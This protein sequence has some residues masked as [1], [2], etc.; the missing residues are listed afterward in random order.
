MVWLI[1]ACFAP[2]GA[3][4]QG[5][6]RDDAPDR[7]LWETVSWINSTDDPLCD[8]LKLVLPFALACVRDWISSPASETNSPKRAGKSQTQRKNGIIIP[9]KKLRI[10]ANW[11]CCW[12]LAPRLALATKQAKGTR[13]KA[14]KLRRQ[15]VA[16]KLRMTGPCMPTYNG[17]NF[18]LATKAT[19][20]TSATVHQQRN[21][22]P[23]VE[24]VSPT[25]WLLNGHNTPTGSCGW[26]WWC[27]SRRTLEMG[28][29]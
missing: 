24:T 23:W 7:S 25:L 16:R 14:P 18:F 15:H 27:C 2:I 4:A 19:M 13:R 22:D 20:G 5:L 8:L 26:S 3:S 29:Q 21:L 11:Q 6:S 17:K 10:N 1:M 28:S 12:Q 9:H